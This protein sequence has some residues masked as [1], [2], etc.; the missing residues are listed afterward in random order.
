M[1]TLHPFVYYYQV[2]GSIKHGNFVLVSDCNTHDTE[3]IYHFQKHLINYLKSQ[4]S[5]RS[6]C[7]ISPIAVVDNRKTK[8]S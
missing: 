7:L 5:M 2:S 4:F 8:T 3:A 6:E 1:A